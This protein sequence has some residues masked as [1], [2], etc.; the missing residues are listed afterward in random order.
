MGYSKPCSVAIDPIEKKPFFHFLPKTEALSIASAGCS[1]RC[2]FCQNWQ[3][4]QFS[5]E[6][7]KK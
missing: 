5:P 6:E 3:I 1:L 7:T 4:S 2:K